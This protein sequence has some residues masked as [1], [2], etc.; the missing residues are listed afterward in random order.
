MKTHDCT[1]PQVDIQSLAHMRR[2]SGL[3]K[4]CLQNTVHSFVLF[5]VAGGESSTDQDAAS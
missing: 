2:P 4:V 5:K 3:I 1:E